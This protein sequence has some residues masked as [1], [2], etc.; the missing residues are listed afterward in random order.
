MFAATNLVTIT[1][2]PVVVTLRNTNLVKPMEYLHDP[3]GISYITHFL[4]WF[5]TTEDQVYIYLDSPSPFS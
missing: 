1:L 2:G 5:I 4:F 3:N